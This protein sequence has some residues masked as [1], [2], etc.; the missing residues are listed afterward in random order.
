MDADDTTEVTTGQAIALC[1]LRAS[2]G[3]LLVWWGLAKVV[4]PGT[5]I[6]IQKQFYG[7]VFGFGAQD[8]QQMFGL[9]QAAIGL[10]VVLGFLRIV[11]LPLLLAIT[12]F[13]AVMIWSALLDPFGLWLPVERISGI[14]HLF[15]P[16]VIILCGAALMLC[17]KAQDR[18]SLDAWLFGGMEA[19]DE[20]DWVLD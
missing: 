7:D 17:F 4:T 16:S 1:A 2:L 3:M 15:Y 12:G 5:G 9:M 19:E 10:C 11:S 18:L 14:Q 20:E 13:S 8:L 6:G